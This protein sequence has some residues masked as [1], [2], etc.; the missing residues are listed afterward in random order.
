MPGT[1]HVVYTFANFIHKPPSLIAN[2]NL[3]TSIPIYYLIK[4]WAMVEALSS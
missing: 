4:N 3:H 2:L 1:D